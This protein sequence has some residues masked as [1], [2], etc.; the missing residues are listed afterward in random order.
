MHVCSR[1]VKVDFH[2]SDIH[3]LIKRWDTLASIIPGQVFVFGGFVLRA[4]SIG[5]LELIDSYAPGHQ[6]R[7]GNLNYVANIRGDMV[8][9]GF[10]A[11]AAT[12]CPRQGDS[13]DP[14]L[15]P[16]QGSTPIPT[17]ALDPGQVSPSAGRGESPA[18]LLPLVELPTEDS[19]AIL[20]L[21]LGN[22][23]E[24]PKSTLRGSD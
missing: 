18:G 20:D 14:L 16:V 9:D 21:A 19:D 12:L 10:A 3:H 11:P 1:I 24:L 17:S 7:F 23:P 8:F 15:D 4:N 5:R 6:I 13:L 2:Q 22:H